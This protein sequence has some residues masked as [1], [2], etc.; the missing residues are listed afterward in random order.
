MVRLVRVVRV[1]RVVRMVRMVRVRVR[2]RVRVVRMLRVVSG[3]KVVRVV[4]SG[5]M[6]IGA[7]RQ[8]W[9]CCARTVH[10]RSLVRKILGDLVGQSQ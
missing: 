4:S 2:L 9:I 3:V 7:K 5:A 1:V 10:A 6:K 8:Q